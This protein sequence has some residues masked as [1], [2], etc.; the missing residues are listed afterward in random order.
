MHHNVEIEI[1]VTDEGLVI[2]KRV[3]AAHP[4]DRVFGILKKVRHTGVPIEHVD[5]YIEEIRGR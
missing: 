5:A 4:V 2:R 1:S 3:E